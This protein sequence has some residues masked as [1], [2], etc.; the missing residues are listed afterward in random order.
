M[1]ITDADLPR[2]IRSGLVLVD[3]RLGIP[4][5]VIV[6][7]FN[8][9]T[10]S[11]T[12]TPQTTTGE[13]GDRSEALRLT[14]P[15]IET[16]QFDADI[17]ATDQFDWPTPNGIHPQLALLELL[18]H[19]PVT[20]LLANQRL[21]DAGTIEITPIQSPLTLWVWGGKRVLP[22][23]VTQLTVNETYFDPDLNPVRATVTIEFR[24]L[25]SN[26]LPTHS[27]GGDLFLAHLA[28]QELLAATA[29]PVGLSWLGITEL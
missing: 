27:L 17:D 21:A 29:A 10:L 22:V 3:P 12:L 4:R 23:R 25:N 15:A 26:D 13:S 2:P 19:P 8:P 11:R 7:Q 20:R 16:W 18:I 6:M 5:R 1:T 14:G 28:Q 9:D 24:V